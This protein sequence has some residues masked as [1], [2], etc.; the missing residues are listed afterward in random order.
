MS[1]ITRGFASRVEDYSWRRSVPGAVATG[2]RFSM[3]YF[4]TII[5]FHSWT[6]SLPLPVL[7]FSNG[8]LL[9]LRQGHRE[10]WILWQR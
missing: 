7:T 10:A 6:R 2:S 3:R 1:K 9:L 8:E 5:D 4:L